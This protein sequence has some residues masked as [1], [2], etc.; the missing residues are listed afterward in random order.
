M[1]GFRRPPSHRCRSRSVQADHAH[2]LEGGSSGCRSS[3]RGLGMSTQGR[4][5]L[6]RRDMLKLSAGGAGG[7]ALHAAGYAVPKG[8]GAGGVVIEAFPTSPLILRPFNDPLKIPQ[9][10]T[11]ADPS[12]WNSLGGR[13]DPNR[14]DSLP[15]SPNN[16]YKNRY[17]PTLGTHQLL[18]GQGVTAGYP[19]KSTTPLVYQIKLEVAGHSF[20]TSQVQPIDSF[21]RNVTPPGAANS[22]PR[23]LPQS[24]IYGFNGSFPGPRINA[25]YGQP[26]LVRFEN[27]L[28]V[29]NGFDRQD[30]GAPNQSF[31]THLHN[32]HTAAESD[33]QP[34][35]AF[36][37]FGP[38]GRFEH[39]AAWEPGEWVDHLY[40]GYPAGGQ[41]RE[42]Q[43][44]F[45][46]HDHV[47][48]HTG[49]DVYK[50]MVGLMPLYDPKI[51]NGDE[52]NPNGLRLPGRRSDNGD[53][54]FNV[55]YDMPLALYDTLLD[56]GVTPHKDIHNGNGETHPEWWGNT[57]YRHLPNHGLVGDI[58]TVNGTAYPVLEVKRRK[59]R[60]RFLDCSISRI[61]ELSLMVSSR[62]PKA[63][64]DLGYSGDELQGQYRL[65]DGEQAMR[66]VQIAT[67]GGLM[68]FP[69]VRNSF[70]LWPAKR[71]EF[72][73]D[74]TRFM[75]GTPTRK[76]DE[77]YLVN[78]MKMT[79]GRMGDSK[80][81]NYKVPLVK[82]VVGDGPPEPDMSMIPA[83]LRDMP[84]IVIPDAFSQVK[85][86]S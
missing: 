85:D 63:A 64:R 3:T 55:E 47:H 60:F 35:Y 31:L 80:D 61:Y 32:A 82:I 62:G 81:Q 26:A 72:V 65:P 83:K 37:R 21:G 36:H 51:D 59:Y 34:H 25:E 30:F 43:S 20:T 41:D 2:P 53:G 70:E 57:F 7:V 40:L 46:F 56:D 86:K 48:G 74:F 33:G 8:Q 39:E 10:L 67:D 23:P 27:H 17:G 29:S 38:F 16:V 68:P 28:D 1:S 58:F 5:R 45:W 18:P 66:M 52:T 44:F 12:T 13:P 6:T 9:A 19:F 14:Q 4:V 76:G 49:A 42:K 22:N 79:T 11:P 24:T 78:T 77:I 50:G 71:R 15:A 73:V 84:P 75:D 69:L 54:S